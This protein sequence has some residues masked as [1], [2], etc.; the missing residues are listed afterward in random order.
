MIFPQSLETLNGVFLNGLLSFLL[1][2]WCVLSSSWVA[3]NHLVVSSLL[4]FLLS[5][6]HS[7]HSCLEFSVRFFQ[8]LYYGDISFCCFALASVCVFMHGYRDAYV[9]LGVVY[10]YMWEYMYAQTTGGHQVSFSVIHHLNI[11][12]GL[13][14]AAHVGWWSSGGAGVHVVMPGFVYAFWG[15]GLRCLCLAG[16]FS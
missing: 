16:I 10:V 12:R 9:C 2:P 13:S 3:Q 11:Q 5:L 6:Y 14:R 4:P 7:N 1:F 15:L 8:L